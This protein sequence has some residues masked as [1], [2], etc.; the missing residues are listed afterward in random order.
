MKFCCD[1]SLLFIVLTVK[2]FLMGSEATK[3]E[4]EPYKVEFSEKELRERLT[5]QQ[6]RVT[7]E[8]GTER[9]FT[10]ELVNNKKAGVYRCVVCGKELFLS[11][12]KFDSGSGWPSFWDTPTDGTVRKITDTSHFMTRTEV[13]CADC[14]AHLGHVFDDGPRPTGQRYCINSASLKFDPSKGK[15]D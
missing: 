2:R 10:G 1:Y 9:A 5:P 6:Y 15:H 7:Q 11:D 13:T 4:Q 3:T 12:T 8:K 14:G